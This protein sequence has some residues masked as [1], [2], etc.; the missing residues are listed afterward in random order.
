MVPWWVPYRN[1]IPEHNHDRFVFVCEAC[2]IEVGRIVIIV[3]AGQTYSGYEEKALSLG[4]KAWKATRSPL[5]GAVGKVVAIDG[6]FVG[7]GSDATGH[8]FVIGR[9]GLK[10]LSLVATVSSVSSPNIR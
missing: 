8:V 7:F 1:S 4:L 10:Y 3:D 9:D 5:D 2:E 6:R